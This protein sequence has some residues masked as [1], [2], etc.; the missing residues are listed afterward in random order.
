MQLFRWIAID[1]MKN[2][3]DYLSEQLQDPE[4]RA[5]YDALE[6][7]FAIIQ[8]MIDDRQSSSP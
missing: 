1:T 6:N 3:N 7:E 4:F 2:F 5:E 8:A